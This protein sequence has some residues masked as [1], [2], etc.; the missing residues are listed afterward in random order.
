MSPRS[1][2]FFCFIIKPYSQANK[3]NGFHVNEVQLCL[4]QENFSNIYEKYF[5]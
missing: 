5:F 4:Q 3:Q 2:P 1:I